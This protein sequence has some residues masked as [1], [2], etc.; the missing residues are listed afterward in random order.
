L[1]LFPGIRDMAL[2]ALEKRFKGSRN[3]MVVTLLSILIKINL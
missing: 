3:R 1:Q 2:H